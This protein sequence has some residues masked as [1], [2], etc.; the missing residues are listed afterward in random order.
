MG[1]YG[2]EIDRLAAGL[3]SI[4]SRQLFN[5][6]HWNSKPPM[7]EQSYNRYFREYYEM[8]AKLKKEIASKPKDEPK[9]EWKGFIN[10]RL[11]E[12]QKAAFLEW[13]VQDSDVWDGV[14]TYA[15]GGYKF[16]V[17]YSATNSSFN[18]TITGQPATGA[19]S[20]WAVSS[21]AKTPYDAVR[22]A[23]YK[24][25]AVLPDVWGTYAADH[26]DTFG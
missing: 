3:K 14:A 24:V 15:E 21:F 25:S 9:F 2:R 10:V 18:C 20:G 7:A 23:L 13:D 5:Q 17:S 26:Q 19:N 6:N 4:R 22:V 12:E 11:S 8:A 16:N 1:L